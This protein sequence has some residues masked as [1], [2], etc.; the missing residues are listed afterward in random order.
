MEVWKL[1]VEL[2]IEIITGLKH[3]TQLH[4]FSTTLVVVPES[5]T[6]GSLIP[7]IC[8]QQ[9]L[10]KYGDSFKYSLSVKSNECSSD[11]SPNRFK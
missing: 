11:A 3:H 9:I 7:I 4:F 6:V 2:E 10:D 1:L 5:V 8:N